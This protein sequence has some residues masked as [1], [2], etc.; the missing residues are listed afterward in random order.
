MSTS[1]RGHLLRAV[2]VWRWADCGA[3]QYLD[4]TSTPPDWIAVVPADMDRPA[5]V[6]AGATA[7]ALS[8]GEV[9]LTWREPVREDRRDHDRHPA[10]VL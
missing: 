3:M 6:P 10:R 9:A 7:H 4:R 1:G 5:W 8:H 2:M